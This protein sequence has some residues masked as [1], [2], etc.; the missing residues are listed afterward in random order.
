MARWQLV[1]LKTSALFLNLPLPELPVLASVSFTF[2]DSWFK[3]FVGVAS[4]R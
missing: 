3:I 1:A 4:G 2:S